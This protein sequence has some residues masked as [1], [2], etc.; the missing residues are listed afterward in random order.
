MGGRCGAPSKRLVPVSKNNITNPSISQYLR[1][2][3][4]TGCAD[5]NEMFLAASY[6]RPAHATSGC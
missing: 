6:D 2:E 3:I 5:L 4:G 1:T